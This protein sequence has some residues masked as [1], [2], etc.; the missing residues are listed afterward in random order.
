MFYLQHPIC[1]QLRTRDEEERHGNTS[2]YSI[3]IAFPLYCCALHLYGAMLPFTANKCYARRLRSTNPSL[4]H[5]VVCAIEKKKPK[6]QY[7]GSL[8]PSNDEKHSNLWKLMWVVKFCEHCVFEWK[9]QHGHFC[10]CATFVSVYKPYHT[11]LPL[12]QPSSADLCNGIN[13][14]WSREWYQSLR[15]RIGQASKTQA[16]KDRPSQ[17]RAREDKQEDIQAS[18]SPICKPKK[19]SITKQR[20]RWSTLQE[21]WEKWNETQEAAEQARAGWGRYEHARAK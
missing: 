11:Y 16:S 3:R 2:V 7:G 15:A 13:Y 6:T 20:P 17:D 9:F 12:L 1:S 5:E 18:T 19:N 4:R 21:R 10:I 8:S 14:L